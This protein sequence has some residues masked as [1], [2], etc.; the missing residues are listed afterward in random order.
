MPTEARRIGIRGQR[1]FYESLN[2]WY[3][4]GPTPRSR[5]MGRGAARR[6]HRHDHH[7]EARVRNADD[8]SAPRRGRPAPER[9]ILSAK[10]AY[11]SVADCIDY[12]EQLAAA[13]A[14]EILFM[15]NMG[16]VPQWAQLGDA[17]Q[18][19]HPCDPALPV[20]LAVVRCARAD[21]SRRG[22]A[23]G[24][25]AALARP[26]RGARAWRLRRAT[27]TLWAW[28]RCAANWRRRAFSNSPRPRRRPDPAAMAAFGRRG[29]TACAGEPVV[30]QCRGCFAGH[31]AGYAAGGL[32]DAVRRQCDRCHRHALGRS[33]PR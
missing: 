3:G 24:I 17:A 31:G 22:A 28:T 20:T 13:G 2:Y 14:D 19:R 8:G 10:N 26:C 25:G 33:C 4:G 15:T 1:Y 5:D 21:R 11:G 6:R 30:R 32:A 9:G 27:A 29:R 18:D 16:T 23:S 12:V 7:H